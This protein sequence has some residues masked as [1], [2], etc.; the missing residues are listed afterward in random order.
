LPYAAIIFDSDYL[1]HHGVKGQKWGVRRYQNP[2]GTWKKGAKKQIKKDIKKNNIKGVAAVAGSAASIIA[3]NSA[4]RTARL[5]FE[6]QR[7][8]SSSIAGIRSYWARKIKMGD[9]WPEDIAR[10]KE[11]AKAVKDHEAALKSVKAAKESNVVKWGIG[12]AASIGLSAYAMHKAYKIRKL[13]K[14]SKDNKIV[15]KDY[16]PSRSEI[17]KQQLKK[18]QRKRRIAVGVG[19]GAG[20]ALAAGAT[21]LGYKYAKAKNRNPAGTTAVGMPRFVDVVNNGKTKTKSA[22]FAQSVRWDTKASR[23]YTQDGKSLYNRMAR[24]VEE[25]EWREIKK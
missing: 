18:A 6:R 17:R 15:E 25:G 3:A 5:Q 23:G 7:F 13:D 16:K 22:G 12:I 2:D 11:A 21:Y 1:E 10:A 8:H 24:V 19:F 20:L 14:L 4:L 9:I